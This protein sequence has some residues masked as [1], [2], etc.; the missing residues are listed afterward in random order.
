[1]ASIIC[2]PSALAHGCRC[3]HC[4]AFLFFLYCTTVSLRRKRIMRAILTVIVCCVL[5]FQSHAQGYFTLSSSPIVGQQPVGLVATNAN[6]DGKVDLISANL[7]S[8]TLSVLTNN[9]GG[10]FV[11]SVNYAVGKWPYGVA[12][13]DVNGDGKMDLICANQWGQHAFGVDKQRQ[14]RLCDFQH[15][16]RRCNAPGL[17]RGGGCQ[18][19]WQ[20]GFDLRKLDTD[21]TLTVLTNNGSG[22]F[23]TS[24]YLSRGQS[25]CS[26]SRRRMSTGMARWI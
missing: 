8:N 15:Q 4:L 6:V 18:R 9:G 26:G 5:S 19:G 21:N 10:S 16:Y 24:G 17:S 23:V 25:G 12:V 22:G 7:G 20:G 13:A 14:W 1:M 11:T 3:V 2:N